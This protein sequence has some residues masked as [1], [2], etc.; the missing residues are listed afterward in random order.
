MT[1]PRARPGV[2][3]VRWLGVAVFSA[4]LCLGAASVFACIDRAETIEEIDAA[5]VVDASTGLDASPG[6][7]PPDRD[8]P[9]GGPRGE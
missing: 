6:G 1:P 3:L 2:G 9:P 5:E 8:G 7:G 4:S